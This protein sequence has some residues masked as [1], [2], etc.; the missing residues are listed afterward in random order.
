MKGTLN[1][2]LNMLL[3]MSET[4][5][6]GVKQEKHSLKDLRS[7]M[8]FQGTLR[9]LTLPS[10]SHSFLRYIMGSRRRM[11]SLYITH[12]LSYRGWLEICTVAPDIRSHNE[13]RVRESYNN[14][15][16]FLIFLG[17]KQQKTKFYLIIFSL[18][19]RYWDSSQETLAW[20]PCK[21]TGLCPWCSI[22]TRSI[23]CFPP[24]RTHFSHY[25]P[26]VDKFGDDWTLE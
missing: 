4:I 19:M 15:P 22:L 23:I 7:V 16:Q 20:I 13:P 2:L 11:R 24:R 26:N 3:T 8:N 6:N 9:S 12:P 21:V 18:L 14:V 25:M 1:M 5:P 10:V 17:K